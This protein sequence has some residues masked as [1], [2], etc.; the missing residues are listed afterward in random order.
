MVS[1]RAVK[2]EGALVAS[3]LCTGFG[4][5]L[6][7]HFVDPDLSITWSYA[8]LHRRPALPWVAA[9]LVVALPP[10]SAAA[11]RLPALHA[12][13][14][15]LSRGWIVVAFGALFA[16]L[17]GFSLWFPQTPHAVDSAEFLFG[18]TQPGFHYN[19]RWYLSIRLY[20]LISTLLVPPLEPEQFARGANVLL[21]T[22]ALMGFAGCARLLSRTRGEFIALTALVWSSFGVLQISVGYLDIYPVPLAAM[23]VYLW[24]AFRTLDGRTSLLWP[25][26]MVALGPF[27]Y[28]GLILLAPSAALLVF[29]R[30]RRDRSLAGVAH[31]ALLSLAAAVFATVGGHGRPLAWR[32]WY[33]E[34]AEA[35]SCQWG[36]QDGSCLLPLEYMLSWAHANEMLHL[37]LLVDGI[38]LLLFIVCTSSELARDWRKIDLRVLV[39][40][41]F[42]AAHL[43]FL[44]VLDPLFGQYSDWDAYT[45]PAVPIT[46]LGG[47][48][49]LTWGRRSPR[50]FGF[51]L[52]LAL[53][54]A[55][56]HALARLNA[57]HV[58]YHHHIEESPC[59]VNCGPPGTYDDTCRRCRWDGVLLLCECRT[60]DG[61][62]RKTGTLQRCP[63]GYRNDDGLLR[64]ETPEV[65]RSID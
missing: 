1:F 36:Y 13:L 4:A 28:I 45:Y 48:G 18:A 33:A 38:G 32:A 27:F 55:S 26:L 50:L 57:M 61:G 11:W 64:C 51:L 37:L 17:L 58:D 41:S 3:I 16:T 25:L 19:P 20:R 54:A 44:L 14:R 42:A 21:G 53:A 62:W 39:L 31:P 34:A 9:M 60:R 2:R 29:D 63:G 8:H 52:G 49:F 24:L 7:L 59:H 46:L 6:L 30:I 40:G 65:G 5:Y 35:A 22:V 12:P 15:P 43:A 23:A 56:V 10:L 47:W